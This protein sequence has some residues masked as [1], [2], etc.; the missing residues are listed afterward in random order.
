LAIGPKSRLQHKYRRVWQSLGS[1][2]QLMDL[3]M[4]WTISADGPDVRSMALRFSLALVSSRPMPARA[5]TV[6]S[7][8]AGSIRIS[9]QADAVGAGA[10]EG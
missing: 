1:L 6:A 5:A 10:C 4:R 9:L 7:C 2:T 8:T 3:L